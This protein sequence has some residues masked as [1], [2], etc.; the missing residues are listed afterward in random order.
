MASKSGSRAAVQKS[1]RVANQRAADSYTNDLSGRVKSGS[2]QRTLRAASG[3]NA[4][5]AQ[6]IKDAIKGEQVEMAGK[7]WRSNP[8]AS[9]RLSDRRWTAAE[10]LAEQF[11]GRITEARIDRLMRAAARG[12]LSPAGLAEGFASKA[13]ADQQK[14]KFM[15]QN[16]RENDKKAVVRRGKTTA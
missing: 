7:A 4:K 11:G 8:T 6:A 13:A 15:D 9:A 10:K 12:V 3:G 1:V 5:A 14:R 2:T 16:R